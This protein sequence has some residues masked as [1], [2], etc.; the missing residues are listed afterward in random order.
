MQLTKMSLSIL[1]R[2][3]LIFVALFLFFKGEEPKILDL[4]SLLVNSPSPNCECGSETTDKEASM[5]RRKQVYFQKTKEIKLE[6][7]NLLYALNN[8]PIQV[9]ESFTFDLNGHT[10]YVNVFLWTVNHLNKGA[11]K[12]NLLLGYVSANGGH[13]HLVSL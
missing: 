9:D 1:I 2:I 6:K 12:R 3:L 5:S 7:E 13:H 10:N 11:R 8:K 4:I